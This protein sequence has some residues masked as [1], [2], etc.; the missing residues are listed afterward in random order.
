[1]RLGVLGLLA[2]VAIGAENWPQFRGPGAMGVADDSRFPDK[3]SETENVAWKTAVPGVGWSSPVVW[4]DRLY[5][6]TVIS[7]GP[8]EEP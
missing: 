1:M 7:S 4:G 3:W 8:L 6:T 5:L 2:A